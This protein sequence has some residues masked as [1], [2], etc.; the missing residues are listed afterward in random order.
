MPSMRVEAVGALDGEKGTYPDGL[1][2]PKVTTQEGAPGGGMRLALYLL[3][4]VLLSACAD[5]G[6]VDVLDAADP[7]TPPNLCGGIEGR[8][9][10][11]WTT[12]CPGRGVIVQR[13]RVD[14]C[15]ADETWT[16]LSGCDLVCDGIVVDSDGFGPEIEVT[17]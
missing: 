2:E 3:V 12:H 4:A 16:C 10:V 13:F 1:A 17:R 15:G 7:D 14:Y 5:G 9:F 8:Y 11:T 6:P